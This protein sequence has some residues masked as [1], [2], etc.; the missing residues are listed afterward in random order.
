MFSCERGPQKR[1]SILREGLSPRTKTCPSVSVVRLG[2]TSTGRGAALAGL[3]WDVLKEFSAWFR[4]GE[5][6][7]FWGM[8]RN[9]VEDFEFVV[10]FLLLSINGNATVWKDLYLVS[11]TCCNS[12]D[13]EVTGG[14]CAVGHFCDVELKGRRRSEKNNVTLTA[15]RGV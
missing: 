15:P 12:L 6:A 10:D 8:G 14:E 11:R 5:K 7:N 3:C 9:G 13:E 2:L 1:E 4:E